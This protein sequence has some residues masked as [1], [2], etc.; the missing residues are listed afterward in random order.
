[1]E[2]SYWK[3]DRITGAKLDRLQIALR[4]STIM[5][6]N[7]VTQLKRRKLKVVLQFILFSYFKNFTV[8]QIPSLGS[9]Q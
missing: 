6:A 3:T 9:L 2:K 1:M 4:T 5:I 7:T 8:I